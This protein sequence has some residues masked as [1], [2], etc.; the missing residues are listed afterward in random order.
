MQITHKV[1]KL[2]TPIGRK[3]V[4]RD[5]RGQ[6]LWKSGRHGKAKYPEIMQS[7]RKRERT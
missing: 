6:P 4:P 2:D 7:T 5:G 1:D 3:Q